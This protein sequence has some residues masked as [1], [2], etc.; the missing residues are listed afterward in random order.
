LYSVRPTG[1]NSADLPNIT[2]EWPR[3]ISYEIGIEQSVAGDYLIRFMGYYKDVTNQ[4][5][6]Q[7]I[8]SFY[9]D[10]NV[11]TYAN[12]SYADIRG[13]ELKIEKRIGRWWYGYVS[14]EYLVKSTGYT[15]L[16]NVYED[17]QKAD[18]EREST[19]KTEEW[20]VPSVI[21]NLTL[22]TPEEFGPDVSGIKPLENWYLNILQEW[23]AGGKSLLNP[24]APIAERH[25]ADVIDYAN[26]DL[27]LEK[28][29]TFKTTRLSFY[30]QVK[31]L[32]NYK[33][34][35]NPQYWNQY[36]G[37]LKFPWEKG[38]QKG[39]DKLGDYKQ[40]YIELGWNTWSQFVN[41]R[42]IFFGLRI[43]F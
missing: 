17:P 9:E 18:Q 2:A 30:M 28:R 16:R 11:T 4:L 38:A 25:W 32:F 42:D 12:N 21:A 5:S 31:N 7:N 13:L 22:R 35:P 14:T 29:F 6:V 24:D 37:S 36:V 41:P 39:N 26:T 19:N 20:P 8:T 23:S 33:G 10:N 15:G 1:S 34:F 27:M 43:Q 40:D 3:T